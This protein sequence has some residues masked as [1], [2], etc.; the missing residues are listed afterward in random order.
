MKKGCRIIDVEG[1]SSP[2]DGTVVIFGEV[3][4][5]RV[6]QVKGVTYPLTGFLGADPSTLKT[7][8]SKKLYHCVLYLAPGDYHRIHS[9]TDWTILKRRHFP[10]TL[11]PV[12]PSFRKLIPN[13]LAL[14]ER[15]SL[16]GQWEQGFFSLSPVGAYNVGSISL[17]FDD[18]KTNYLRRDF[19]CPNLRYFSFGGVG[20]HAY[21]HEYKQPVSLKKG[22]EMGLFNLGST[23]VLVFESENFDFHVRAGQKVQM[24]EKIGKV[25]K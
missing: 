4:A 9:P 23:V 15:I 22:D 20:T 1:M 8:P 5:D 17:N 19:R 10:G 6:E 12:S 3:K 18:V 13:L 25:R 11:F 21:E 7:F 2:V 14:N 24:G 16:S